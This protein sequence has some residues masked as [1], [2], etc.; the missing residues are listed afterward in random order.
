MGSNQ[1]RIKVLMIVGGTLLVALFILVAIPRWNVPPPRIHSY[2]IFE[3]SVS[4]A[5]IKEEFANPRPGRY[6]PPHLPHHLEFESKGG[7]INVYVLDFSR[8]PDQVVEMMNVTEELKAGRPPERFV[9]HATG[10]RGRIHLHSWPYGRV[11]YMVLIHAEQE[12][13]VT[14]KVLYAG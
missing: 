13:E 4:R 3:G 10:E 2:L 8:G 11:T 1:R 5:V 12:S 9:A 14:L 6:S 7:P